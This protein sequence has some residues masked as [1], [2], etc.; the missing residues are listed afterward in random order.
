MRPP[1]PGSAQ[2][3]VTTQELL[4]LGAGRSRS[5]AAIHRVQAGACWSGQPTTGSS[6]CRA[7]GWRRRPTGWAAGLRRWSRAA[8][9]VGWAAWAAG[10][11]ATPAAASSGLCRLHL[12]L[13]VPTTSGRTREATATWPLGDGSCRRSVMPYGQPGRSV[14][15]HPRAQV[16][17]P[18]NVTCWHQAARGALNVNLTAT[19]TR[20]LNVGW[21]PLT[22]VTATPGGAHAGRFSRR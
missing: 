14:Q 19:L 9:W 3:G 16:G 22:R 6:G 8:C 21:R 1:C 20:L 7:L 10:G 13:E 17:K 5:D 15:G 2:V 18:V 11:V 4:G 12:L